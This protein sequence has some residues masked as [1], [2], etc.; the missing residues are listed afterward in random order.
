M[1]AVISKSLL[2]KSW[3]LTFDKEPWKRKQ[4][5]YAPKNYLQLDWREA[6]LFF[7]DSRECCCNQFLLAPATFPQA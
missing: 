2:L 6:G 7:L 3:F 5:L 4:L 1:K